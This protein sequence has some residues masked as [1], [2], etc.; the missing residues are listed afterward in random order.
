MNKKEGTSRTGRVIPSYVGRAGQVALY[1]AVLSP[2]ALS[3]QTS[4]LGSLT[5]RF[6]ESAASGFYGGP[7]GLATWLAIALGTFSY[8]VGLLFDVVTIKGVPGIKV[9]AVGIFLLLHGLALAAAIAGTQHF[10]L[11][12]WSAIVG[13]TTLPVFVALLA[14]SLVFE[15]A[16]GKTYVEAGPSNHLVTTGTYALSRH[17]GVLWYFLALCSLILATRSFPL[18]IAAP[19]WFLADVAYV[20]VQD[21]LLFP[22]IFPAYHQYQQVTPMLI[23]T[24][25]S[26]GACLRTIKRRVVP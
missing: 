10:V 20:I 16:S 19:M 22:K 18:L 2:F 6:Q 15:L 24:L 26:A 14:Y 11:P 21:R 1:P 9:A 25:K 3:F 5:T 17:P 8:L 12:M 13:W 23:P 4:S 7:F